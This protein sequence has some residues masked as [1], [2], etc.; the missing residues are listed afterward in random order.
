MSK[1]PLVS[2]ILPVYNSE[3]YLHEAVASILGQTLTDFELIAIDDGSTDESA[4]ILESFQ[5]NDPRVIFERYSQNRGV[6]AALN[7]GLALARGKYIARMDADD[8]SLPERFEKQVAFLEKHP[9]IDILGTAML[10]VNERGR[11]I[12][13]LSA[14]LDEMAIRWVSTFSSSFKQ[15]TI[16]YRRSVI[17]EHDLR[18]RGSKD[19]SEDLDFSIR[20][21]EHA[22]GAN[23][24]EELYI[25]R[26]RSSSITGQSSRGNVDRTSDIVIAN[27]QKQ[28]PGVAISNDQVQ[29][30]TGAIFGKPSMRWKRAEAAD[31]YLR[32]WQTFSESHSSDPGFYSLQTSVVLIAAKLILYP[33]FQ[34][35]WR[36]A[37]RRIFEIEPRWFLLFISRFPGMISTKMVSLTIQKNRK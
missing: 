4:T 18:Y 3:K 26:V 10:L 19:Q 8:V 12:G 16:M 32:V 13:V 14:P 35:G 37:L 7:T 31:T 30:V 28:F 5:K 27:I 11:K 25:Y 33:P 22:R 21:L 29:Q 34:R 1:D 17:I 2:V 23:I 20:F 6:V 15:P 24:A 9:D 36:K